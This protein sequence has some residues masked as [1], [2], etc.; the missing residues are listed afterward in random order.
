MVWQIRKANDMTYS[1][2]RYE[3]SAETLDSMLALLVSQ[4]LV[5]GIRSARASDYAITCSQ[6]L[7][8]AFDISP[9]TRQTGLALFARRIPQA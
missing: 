5:M 4:N 6:K 9:E 8:K 3:I 1:R 2:E 7:A